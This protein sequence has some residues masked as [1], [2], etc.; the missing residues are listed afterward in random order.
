[1]LRQHAFDDDVELNVPPM[2]CKKG[3][4]SRRLIFRNNLCFTLRLLI[5]TSDARCNSLTTF[6]AN[7]KHLPLDVATTKRSWRTVVFSWL[8]WRWRALTCHATR[9]R[10]K[11]RLIV[12]RW[13]LDCRTTSCWRHPTVSILIV[14]LRSFS[15]IRGRFPIWIFCKHSAVFVWTRV[16]NDTPVDVRFQIVCNQPWPVVS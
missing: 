14:L 12:R 15:E 9:K 5:L 8:L 6:G 3:L 2:Y 11:S 7:M 16:W 13:A 10:L 4:Q 1:M